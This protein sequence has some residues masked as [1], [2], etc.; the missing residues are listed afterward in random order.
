MAYLKIVWILFFLLGFNIVFAENDSEV[1]NEYLKLTIN[2]KC[3][4]ELIKSDR[5][6]Y[7][8]DMADR[9]SLTSFRRREGNIS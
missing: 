9:A 7:L 4:K 3:N 1:S 8:C 5:L 2:H 6:L